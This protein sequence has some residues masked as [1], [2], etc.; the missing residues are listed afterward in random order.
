LH[1]RQRARILITDLWSG[2]QNGKLRVPIW[3]DA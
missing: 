3:P 2:R 1:P